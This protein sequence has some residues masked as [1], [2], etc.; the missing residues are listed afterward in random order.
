MNARSIIISLFLVSLFSC[1]KDKCT[2]PFPTNLIIGEHDLCK[3]QYK[4]YNPPIIINP[5]TDGNPIKS[6]DLTNDGSPD[7]K[8]W[9]S[10]FN[11]EKTQ[12]RSHIDSIN[13]SFEIIVDILPDSVFICSGHINEFDTSLPISYT[14]STGF[15][16]SNP[17][18]D[19]LE[20]IYPIA[21]PVQFNF[22]DTLY[23]ENHYDYNW[24]NSGNFSLIWKGPVDVYGK[25]WFCYYLREYWNNQGPKYLCFRIN[26][27]NEKINKR[28]VNK[29]GWLK[30]EI[31]DY[32]EIK[33]YES[34]IQ[35]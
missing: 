29:Y 5:E 34:A 31:I 9:S 28:D 19:S 20:G 3:V 2:I 22:Q 11:G 35:N 27:K 32:D 33:L 30:I 17:E 21:I 10:Y 23:V 24:D 8:L 26:L 4:V 13:K 15:Q 6:F 25:M 1:E 7:F 12:K 14:A 18:D 16:C